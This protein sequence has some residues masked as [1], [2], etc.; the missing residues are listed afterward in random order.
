MSFKGQRSINRNRN[1]LDIVRDMLVIAITK[2]R[3]TRIMYQANLN[4]VQLETYMK[5]LL[6][7]GLL[8]REGG[9]SY[10]TT[11]KGQEFLRLY[12]EYLDRSR[13]L[14]EE[15]DGTVKHRQMLENMCFS[16]KH[17]ITQAKIWK[18]SLS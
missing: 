11:E 18:D 10:L 9:S 15:V 1:R 14:V 6:D 16:T 13:R 8:A 7:K 17:E 12:T 3:K 5:T 4:Y 2:V